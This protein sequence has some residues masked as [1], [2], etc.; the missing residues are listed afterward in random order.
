MEDFS[1]V[2]HQNIDA[3]VQIN[4]DKKLSEE[5]ARAKAEA[6]QLDVALDEAKRTIDNLSDA[7][8]DARMGSG[9]TELENKMQK[10]VQT[11]ERSRKEFLSFLRSVQMDDFAHFGAEQDYFDTLFT[12]ISEG[13]KTA[14]E[15]IAEVKA[16][17]SE[18]VNAGSSSSGIMDSQMLRSFVGTLNN[19]ASSVD[20]VQKKLLDLE[21]NGIKAVGNTQSGGEV[22]ATFEQIKN[23]ID[24]MANS[25]NGAYEPLTKL[26]EAI[27]LYASID[28]SK[29]FAVS[30]AVTGLG[31]IG[32]G[33]FSAKSVENVVNLLSRLQS[34]TASGSGTINF[35][36]SGLESFEN[37][38]V[39]KAS[40]NNLATFL[41]QIASVDVGK[42]EQLSRVDLTNFN[43]LDIKKTSMNNLVQMIEAINNVRIDTSWSS[44][45]IAAVRDVTDA[46]N[47]NKVDTSWSDDLIELIR[48]MSDSITNFNDIFAQNNA[49]LNIDESAFRGLEDVLK[50]INDV[51]QH[52]DTSGLSGEMSKVGEVAQRVAIYL[53]RYRDALNDDGTTKVHSSLTDLGIAA[54]DADVISKHLSDMNIKVKAITPEWETITKIIDGEIVKQQKLKQITVQG[55]TALGDAVNHVIKFSAK[56]GE[57]SKELTKATVKGKEFTR[58]LADGTKETNIETTVAELEEIDGLIKSIEKTNSTLNSS[59]NK[60]T[61]A[62]GGLSTT[63]KNREELDAINKK[64]DE[65]MVATERLKTNRM[66]AN[67]E[68]V[69]GLRKVQEE[70][71]ALIRKSQ[72]RL[73]LEAEAD[74]KPTSTKVI[75]FDL[76]TQNAQASID[77]INRRNNELKN[78][79]EQVRQSVDALN[80]AFDA[81]DKETNQD[82]KKESLTE[83]NKRIQIANKL[84]SE[85]EALQKKLETTEKRKTREATQNSN[86]QNRVER[87]ANNQRKV[88]LE[89]LAK[90]T[91]AQ[92]EWTKAQNGSTS[93]EYSKLQ[94]YSN[95]LNSLLNRFSSKSITSESFTSQ[96]KEINEQFVRTSSVIKTAGEDTNTLAD[97][98][99]YL[100]EKFAT[101][102]SVSRI[103]MLVTNNI[104]QMISA[105]IELD[106][107]MTQLQIVTKENDEVMAKFGDTAAAAAKRIGSSITDFV[108]SA[109]T[110]ARLGYSLNESSQLAEFTAMLQNVGDIDVSEAQD[111]ITSIVKAFNIGTD[112]IE[113]V[114]DKMVVSGNNFPISVSQIAE[115]MKNAS[116]ALAAA[117]NSFDQSVALLTAAN[118]TLQDSA[119]S[120]TGLRTIA[121]RIRRTKT[122]LDDLGETISEAEYEKL[123]KALTD[124]NVALTENGEYRSTYDIIKD[125]AAQWKNLTSME[126]AALTEALAGTRQQSVFS[127]LVN[128][129]QEASGAMEAMA[130]SAG[131]LRESYAT[132]MESAEAHINQLKAAFESLAQ[133]TFNSDSIKS[134]V[135]MLAGLLTTLDNIVK[136]IGGVPTIITGIAAALSAIKNVGRGK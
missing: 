4:T 46:V 7:L 42:L 101:W 24:G 39:R 22:V 49:S 125:I 41:P 119:K 102:F 63:G 100:S 65:L 105:S 112:Q 131:E 106:K 70:L 81:Y 21:A 118:S 44:D 50:E 124:M 64:F 99:G 68:D 58:T 129:F 62:L 89:L 85:Q 84:L 16:Y 103:I 115:G 76:E 113:S 78:S 25:A 19:I 34:L 77:K 133:S 28:N 14:S 98:F 114:M 35:N 135:D 95:Q 45:L 134:V 80:K 2:V 71:D 30:Q 26:I 82:R 72:K 29:L 13:A 130:S 96:V 3:S 123:I 31:E 32:K 126:Q 128:N 61:D 66:T 69:D 54:K 1:A 91:K 116:S 88:A 47:N 87:E 117:G 18:L 120:S 108:S 122:E 12:D 36:V 11:A 94:T 109:T 15:A 86:K 53:G 56:T 75:N 136:T 33:S 20:A 83:V 132:Y 51:I 73:E 52:S 37:L 38:T 93:N 121:A 57:I 127:G 5:L 27:S 92:Q 60:V 67:Q 107:S 90:I 8:D 40:L 10:F 17:Y 43:N 9:I 23:T 104:R 6:R 111:A 74:K 79:T 110:Y 48:N 55:T 97:K 59:R